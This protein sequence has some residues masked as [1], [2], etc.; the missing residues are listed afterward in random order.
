MPIRIA[1]A[2]DHNLVVAVAVAARPQTAKPNSNNISRKIKGS[3]LYFFLISFPVRLSVA[4]NRKPQVAVAVRKSD[5][6]SG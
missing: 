2:V 5:R 4:V 1:V 6:N 3:P